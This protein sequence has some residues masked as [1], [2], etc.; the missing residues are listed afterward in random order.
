MSG[1]LLLLFFFVSVPRRG[2]GS[3]DKEN[4]FSPG[5]LVFRFINNLIILF[6]AIIKEKKTF[7]MNTININSYKSPN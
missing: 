1:F 7:V 3:M 6:I 2:L 5:I 4:A